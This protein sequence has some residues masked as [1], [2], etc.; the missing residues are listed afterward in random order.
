MSDFPFALR[1][2]LREVRRAPGLSAFLVACVAIGVAALTAISS[3]AH[4]V[5][6]AVARDARSLAS[7]DVVVESGVPLDASARE[8]IDSWQ[9]KGVREA[10]TA[11]FTSMAASEGASLSS[12]VEIKAVVGAYP[13]YGALEL[14]PPLPLTHLLTRGVVVEPTLLHKLEL[15]VGGSLRLGTGTFPVVGVVKFEPD[16]ASGPFSLGPRVFLSMPSA[17]EAGLLVPGSRVRFRSLLALPEGLSP[18]TVRDSLLARVDEGRTSVR[19]YAQA[20]P[21]LRSFLSGMGSF[22]S[23]TTLTTLLLGGVGV[24]QSL[25]VLLFRQRDSIAV[26]KVLGATSATVT[27][28]Y[29][30]HAMGLAALGSLLGI[31]LGAMSQVALAQVIGRVIPGDVDL[32]F[33]PAAALQGGIL[34]LASGLLSSLFPLLSI[35]GISPSRVLRREDGPLP[36]AD[37]LSLGLATAVLGLCL[38]GVAGWLA[39]SGEMGAWF[40][41]GMG[42]AVIL[43]WISTRL[44]LWG[45]RRLPPPRW[46]LLRHGLSGLHRPGAQTSWVVISLGLGVAAIAVVHLLQVNLLSGVSGPRQSWAPDYF[47][48]NIQP[49]QVED[50]RAIVAS[51]GASSRMEILPLV[52]ARLKRIDGRAVKDM[53]FEDEAEERFLTRE[54]ANTFR[55]DLPPGNAVVTGKWWTAEESA[56][57]SWISVEEDLA[58]QLQLSPGSEVVFDIQGV[59]VP[60]RV[61][62]IRSVDWARIQTNFFF[63]GTRKA[64][65]EAPATWVST[66]QAGEGEEARLAL[67]EAVV[68]RLPGVTAIQTRE[69][70]QRVQAVVDRVSQVIRVLAASTIG[71]GLVILAGALASGR[72]QRLR[73]MALLKTLGATRWI[74]LGV[75]AWEWGILGF[76]AGTVGTG[77]GGGIAFALLTQVLDLPFHLH[78]AILLLG[79]LL[80]A[81]ATLLVGMISLWGV[82]GE[83]PLQV[84]RND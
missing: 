66:V 79:P 39:G 33:S 83:S 8:G 20:Q 58:H 21:G 40:L 46:F 3:F 75:L 31:L 68:R 24:A 45:A 48:I 5:G 17:K 53:A 84:L 18:E 57:E 1:M 35:R 13:F 61:L 10:L 11:E 26:L 64:F 25:R 4:N 77:A 16:R 9:R 56:A 73:E 60:T 72:F 27:R 49:A 19:T 34:G 65:Q 76:L 78:P 23:L 37:R 32:S 22:L 7:A 62:S 82:W 43:L 36:A 41:G 38:L 81:L 47:F 6:N 42:G 12:V 63:I 2:A 71:A 80:T 67:Q 29:L 30:L 50:F 51:Q 15:S 54:F 70:I 74:L 14:D 52:Q 28:V 59:E 55:D 44:L 69:T